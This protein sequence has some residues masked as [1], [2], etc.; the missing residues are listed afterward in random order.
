MKTKL[1]V[2]IL[3][4]VLISVATTTVSATPTQNPMFQKLKILVS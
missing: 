1:I 3:S 4:F 2:I